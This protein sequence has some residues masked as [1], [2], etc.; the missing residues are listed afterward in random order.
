MQLGMASRIAVRD[1]RGS[2]AK[3]LFIVLAVAAGV[4]AVS[5]VRGFSRSFRAGILR[6]ARQ[7]MAADIA[8]NMRDRS[9]PEQLARVDQLEKEGIRHTLVQQTVSMVSSAAMPFPA[10]ASLKAV[11]PARYPFYGEVRLDP[12]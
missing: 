12:P 9:D 4:G 2:P 10:I 3:F 5:G 8:V 7:L 6:E 11:D 1:L